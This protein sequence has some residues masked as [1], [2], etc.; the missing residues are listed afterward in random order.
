MLV[1][2]ATS[3]VCL[4]AWLTAC[5]SPDDDGAKLDPDSV[6][7]QAFFE[8]DD[9]LIQDG[10]GTDN[11]SNV[12]GAG[13]GNC[14]PNFTGIV[15]DFQASHPDFE[16]FSGNQIS[17]GIVASDLGSDK[18]PVYNEAGPNMVSMGGEMV[19][20]SNPGNMEGQQTTSKANFDQWYRDTPGVNQSM[21]YAL[22]FEAAGSG[23]VFDSNSFFPAD[24]KLFGNEGNNHNFWFT[25]EL[26]MQ[27][28]YNGGEVFTFTGD[29]DV[30][31]FI[32]NKLAVDVGGLHPAQSRTID[33]DAEADR[34]GIS[35]GKLYDLDLFHAERHTTESNFRVETS[36]AFVNCEPIFVSAK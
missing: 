29:D 12:L 8:G 15:R 20:F 25:Y 4:A 19:Y 2:S 33:L 28:T 24:D 10:N 7:G 3:V 32:N 14:A 1:R 26:H 34:L 31:V 13:N 16:A 18:K 21:E 36:I 5:G 30:W 6:E 35:R 27:F 11:G 22:P 23:L 17:P 9:G